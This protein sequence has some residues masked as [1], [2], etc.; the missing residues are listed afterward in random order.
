MLDIN[1]F[2]T[3]TEFLQTFASVIAQL[4]T[5]FVQVLLGWSL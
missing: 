3:S 2:F 1:G 4:I 5:G